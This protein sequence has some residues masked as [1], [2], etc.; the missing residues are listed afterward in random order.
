MNNLVTYSLAIA[1]YFITMHIHASVVKHTTITKV[2]AGPEYGDIVFITINNKSESTPKCQNNPGHDYAFD[3]TT[4]MGLVTL[5]LV[6][7]AYVHQKV[8]QISGTDKCSNF[9][10]VEDLRY[11]M[12]K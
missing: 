7:E 12:L 5:N 10:N 3:P 6:I 1:M 11:I 4:D 9:S 8:V 2:L